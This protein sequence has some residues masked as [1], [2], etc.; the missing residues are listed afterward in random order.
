MELPAEIGLKELRIMK[1]VSRVIFAFLI[2]FFSLSIWTMYREV[3]LWNEFFFYLLYALGFT[4]V[5]ATVAFKPLSP[6]NYRAAKTKIIL[7]FV[8]FILPAIYFICV[9]ISMADIAN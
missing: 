5:V 6:L 3:R 2:L 8:A 1:L 7:T 4:C 9:M